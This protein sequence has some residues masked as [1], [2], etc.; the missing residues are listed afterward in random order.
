MSPKSS[1]APRPRRVTALDVARLAGVS[2]SAV[3]RTLTEGASVSAETRQ[4]VLSAAEKLGYHRNALVR[5]MITRRSGIIGVITG[6]LENPFLAVALERL[7]RRLQREG[8]KSFIYSG[9]A[10]SDLQSALPGMIEYRVDGCMFL[11]NDLSPDTAAKYV[12]LGIPLV[13]VFSPG[14]ST[15]SGDPVAPIGS[16]SVDSFEI[17]RRMGHLMADGGCRRL[18]YLSGHP[19]ST[20]N[21]LRHEGF[22]QGLSERGAILSSVATGNFVYTDAL[23]GAR[24]LLSS[25]EPIDAIY[26]GNDLMAMAALDVARGELGFAVPHQLA[27]AGFDDIQLAGGAAYDLTTVRQPVSTMIDLAA[28]LLLEYIELPTSP[29]R[30][31]V[32]DAELVR[33]GSTR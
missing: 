10:E 21:R 30:K 22:Q 4:K 2:R 12:G 11:T 14:I 18:A 13:L 23:R 32:V 25:A 24:R 5:G 6:G 9:D 31:I 20:S 1:P 27:V 28:D 29:S 16:V 7:A 3:S 26:C 17:S 15:T 33:R 8:L 19:D